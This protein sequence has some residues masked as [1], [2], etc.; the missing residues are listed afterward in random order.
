PVAL[1]R[2]EHA[3]ARENGDQVGDSG[4]R[5][6]EGAGEIGAMRRS[7]GHE[8]S[9]YATGRGPGAGSHLIDGSARRAE[10]RSLCDGSCG[11]RHD[12]GPKCPVTKQKWWRR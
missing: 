1:E 7:D 6:P 11:M 5:D 12:W 10:S 9:E 2:G 4:A 3:G 8:V